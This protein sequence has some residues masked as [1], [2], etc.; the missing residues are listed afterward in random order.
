MKSWIFFYFAALSFAD[1][2][3]WLDDG[4]EVS[5][6]AII[7]FNIL[8]IFLFIIFIIW[9]F[10]KEAKFVKE[11]SLLLNGLPAHWQTALPVPTLSRDE[12]VID[13]LQQ[14]ATDITNQLTDI[15][16]K[17]V[18]ENDYLAAWVHE[19]KAPLT[20][21]K[22]MI[23]EHRDVQIIQKLETEWLRLHLLIDRQLYISRLSTLESDY[24]LEKVCIQDLIHAEIRELSSWCMEKNLAIEMEGTVQHVVIDRKWCRFIIRQLLTNAV[25][26]SPSGGT[27]TISV[28]QDQHG[29]QAIQI[30][31][32]GPGIEQHDLPRIFDKGFT[33]STGR[34]HNA[35]TGLGLYLAKLVAD[36]IGMT[37]VAHSELDQGTTMVMLFS[38][39][40]DFIKILT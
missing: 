13:V 30:K 5:V 11:L 12:V 27:I 10:R 17:H 31:D 4:I 25:K 8:L 16:E 36:K 20:A 18:I 1:V 2:L 29:F 35:A 15:R 22:M 32:G 19:V 37:I 26:Y 39:E 9:R 28:S 24:L 14:V 38:Q 21:M 3:I 40:N 33:G 23:D 7:Y 6:M 34:L